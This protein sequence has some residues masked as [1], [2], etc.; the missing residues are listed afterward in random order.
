MTFWLAIY[1]TLFPWRCTHIGDLKVGYTFYA[2]PWKGEMYTSACSLVY[3]DW[4]M[5]VLN[6]GDEC[7]EIAP[8]KNLFDEVD[9]PSWP[10]H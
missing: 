10:Y 7:F 1:L 3:E 5:C 6:L 4:D 2:G 8:S 9:Q